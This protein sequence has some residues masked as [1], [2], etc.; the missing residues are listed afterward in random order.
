MSNDL[1]TYQEECAE[2]NTRT[3]V[4]DGSVDTSRSR[5]RPALMSGHVDY[6]AARGTNNAGLPLALSSTARGGGSSTVMVGGDGL[7]DTAISRMV[8]D[9]M[10][11]GTGYKSAHPDE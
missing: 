5:L 2:R 1:I 9:K 7:P 3:G 8:E 11:A 6:R 10:C 4:I